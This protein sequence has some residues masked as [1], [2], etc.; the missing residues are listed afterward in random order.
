[1][2]SEQQTSRQTEDGFPDPRYAWYV[3]FVLFFAY[4]VSF[5]D[6]QI[7]TLLVE[8]IKADLDFDD[9]TVEDVS[10]TF[11][12]RRALLRLTFRAT[13]G[14]ILGLLGPNGAGKSTMIAVLATLLRP[15]GGRVRYGMHE[16]SIHG[17][18]LSRRQRRR[19]RF[20][21]RGGHPACRGPAGGPSSRRPRLLAKARAAGRS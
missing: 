20:R 12:R 13:R 1:M 7:L 8:P 11:G 6:R 16:S 2:V 15:S 18:A 10:R 3:V 21:R 4:V 5:L 14:G 19:F 17:P 9:V